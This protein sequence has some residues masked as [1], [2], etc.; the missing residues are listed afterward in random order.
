MVKVVDENGQLVKA[1]AKT[2]LRVKEL[3]TIVVPGVAKRDDAGNLTV[4]ATR[5]FVRN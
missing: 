5:V 3:S 1:D 4:L 2:L